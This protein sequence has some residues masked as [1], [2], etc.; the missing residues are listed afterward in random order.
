MLFLQ[1]PAQ[2]VLGLGGE[3]NEP[4]PLALSGERNEACF[5]A[6]GLFGSGARF[7]KDGV[8]VRAAEAETN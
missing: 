7:K 2:R 8:T 5:L 3:W 4:W 6:L 1:M